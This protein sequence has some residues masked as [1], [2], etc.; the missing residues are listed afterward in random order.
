VENPSATVA[1]TNGLATPR[2]FHQATVIGSGASQVLVITGGTNSIDGPA[3]D[4]EFFR[5]EGEGLVKVDSTNKAPFPD[6]KAPSQHLAVA[7]NDESLLVIGGRQAAPG[8]VPEGTGTNE[9]WVVTT[10]SGVRQAPVATTTL[11]G[12]FGHVG[13]KMNDGSIIVIGGT[14]ADVSPAAERISQQGSA[15]NFVSTQL[16]GYGTALMGAGLAVLPTNQLFVSGGFTTV[17][18][19]TTSNEASLYFGR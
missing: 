5:L 19:R 14:I 2:A 12:R 10:A 7:L 1:V 4:V 11:I 13:A 9:M 16:A 8:G 17:E 18:P 15:E 3:R 6:G